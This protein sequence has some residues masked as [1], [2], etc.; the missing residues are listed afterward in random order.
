MLSN[1][2]RRPTC[3]FLASSD[4]VA[5]ERLSPS[6]TVLIRAVLH[7]D[8]GGP[9]T[10]FLRTTGVAHSSHF[11]SALIVSLKKNLG[12]EIQLGI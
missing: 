12:V 6:E 10:Q 3:L 7:H 11:G 9:P 8:S 2:V 4:K 5:V 1:R